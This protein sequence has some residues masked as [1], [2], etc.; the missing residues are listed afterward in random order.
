MREGGRAESGEGESV[1]SDWKFICHFQTQ[2][3]FKRFIRD[4]ASE[5][6]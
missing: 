3:Y 4:E 6:Q 1:H 2:A 5:V